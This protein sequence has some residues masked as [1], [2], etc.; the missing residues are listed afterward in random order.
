MTASEPLDLAWRYSLFEAIYG[1]RSRRFGLGFE[2]PTGPF[3]YKSTHAPLPL[4]ELEEALLV[5]AGAGFTGLALWDL[6]TPAPYSRRSGRAFPTT[7][8]G[9]QTALF[10]TNDEG[11]YVLDD[12]V[13]ASKPREIESTEERGKLLEIYRAQRRTLKPGRLDIP[14]RAPTMSGHDHWDSNRPGSTLFMPVC[15][16]SA[17]LISLIAQFVDPALR[18]YAAGGRGMNIVDDRHGF[19]PAGTER[20]LKD[21]LIDAEQVLPLSIVER[22]ACYYVFS[23]PAAICQNM[24]LATEAIGLGGWKHC[25]FLSLGILERMG[26]RIVPAASG[27]L[28]GNPIGLDG[29]FEASC[30]PYHASMDA[31][32]D[33]AFSRRASAETAVVPH[34]MSEADHRAGTVRLSAEGL[35]CTKAVCNYIYETYGRFPA[36]TDAMHLMWVMQAHHIDTDYY[37]RFFGANAYGSTHAAHM[38]NWHR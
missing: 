32:V 10:F 38:A 19:R 12:D 16:V 27:G 15:D 36:T 11:F 4:T 1:R 29:V 35:A 5:G 31:A 14:R 22:Q 37:D 24:F 7:H 17:S 3:R 21:G 13:A 6:P 18:R 28:F 30:P 33:A 9:G 26:F 34:R 20:W 8:P 25:G 23:E 2:M